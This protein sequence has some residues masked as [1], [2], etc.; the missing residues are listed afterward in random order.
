MSAMRRLAPAVILTVACGGEPAASSSSSGPGITSVSAASTG[1]ESTT[2]TS[3]STSGVD[4]SSTGAA[5]TTTGLIPDMGLIPDFGPAQPPGC[6]GKIDFLFLISRTGTMNM[7]QAALLTSLPGFIDTIEANFPD[8][9]TH[10]MVANPD[11]PWPGWT[12]AM[13]ELCSM[14][15]TCGP[16]APD[17]K[18]GQDTWSLIKPCDETLGA[19]IV[20]N[21][22]AYATN[23]PCS[24]AE[25]RRYMVLPGEPDPKIAFDCIARVGTWGDHPLTGDALIAAVSPALNAEN[26]CNA[27]FLRPEALLVVTI[28]TD[29]D[30]Y[31]SA[32][33]PAD[34]YSAIV[35][36]KGDPGA[37]VMLSMLPQVLIGEAK[38][39]CSYDD[40]GKLRL[41]DFINMFPFHEVGDTCATSYV[42]FFEKAASRVAEACSD[43]A[44]Q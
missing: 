35:K 3:T 23:Y 11:G 28:I 17:F 26:S 37:V 14:T 18:C 29:G 20:F 41:L 12:C 21:A 16:Y 34:W 38:P 43:F 27:G 13:P 33:D 22:G 44:P 30:D 2:S 25:G 32:T 42:P 19:G 15:K 1:S 31:E 9:D 36:A 8:F 10:V 24:L 39:G 40:D 7:E 6:K 5:G 4:T